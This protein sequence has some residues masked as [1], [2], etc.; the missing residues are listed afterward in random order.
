MTSWIFKS[1]A[2]LFSCQT[3]RIDAS[4]HN[5]FQHPFSYWLDRCRSYRVSFSENWSVETKNFAVI[6]PLVMIFFQSLVCFRG[7]K[8][9]V[10]F[11]RFLVNDDL[12]AFF[13]GF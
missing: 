5:I 11:A 1:C 6:L 10:F 12:S 13:I 8:S 3:S 2:Y 7:K 9:H 4:S